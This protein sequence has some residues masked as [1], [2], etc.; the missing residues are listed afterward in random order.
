[1]MTNTIKI[2]DSIN[3]KIGSFFSWA[4]LILV[5][6]IVFDVVLR[7]VFKVSYIWLSEVEVYVFALI[8]LMGIGYTLLHDQH[9]RV[10]VFYE[11]WSKRRRAWIN[12]FGT[13]FF[14]IPWCIVA[15]LSA[16]KYASFSLSFNEGSA[17]PGGLPCLYILKFLIVLAFVLLL[18]QGIVLLLKSILTLTSEKL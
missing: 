14:L 7:Y 8:F 16:W 11:K 17:Q 6:L 15:I 18:I 12:I 10:D 4:T 3:M 9:V 2:L 13:M 1:M 5:G